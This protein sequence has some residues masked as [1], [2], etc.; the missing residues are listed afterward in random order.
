MII[1]I[2]GPNRCGK[3]TQIANLKNYYECKGMRVHVIHYEHIHLNP[4]KVYT[5]DNM[6]DMAFVRY[7]DML[8]LADEFAK[9]PHTVIIF[10]R[11][12]LGTKIT[13]KSG[14]FCPNHPLLSIFPFGTGVNYSAFDTKNAFPKA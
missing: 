4:E 8:R 12:H 2:E 13:K 1:V 11:A 3:S 5:S 14:R 9:D 10:D 7:D 6:K